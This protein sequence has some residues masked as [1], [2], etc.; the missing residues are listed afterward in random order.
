M[1]IQF[2]NLVFEGR[3]IRRLYKV[4]CLYRRYEVLEE[5]GHLSGIKRVGGTSVGAVNRFFA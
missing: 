3:Y 2:R 1:T 5:K 4:L